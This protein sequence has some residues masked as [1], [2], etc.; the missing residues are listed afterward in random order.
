MLSDN[1]L[2]LKFRTQATNAFALTVAGNSAGI[3][4]HSLKADEISVTL[5]SI[6][7]T[8]TELVADIDYRIINADI[9][10]ILNDTLTGDLKIWAIMVNHNAQNPAKLLDKKSEVVLTPIQHW[11]PAHGYH[12]YAAIHNIDL[13]DDVDPAVFGVTERTQDFTNDAIDISRIVPWGKPQVGTTWLDTHEVDY[14]PYYDTKAFPD[15][16]DRISYW[17][18]LADWSTINV[19]EWVRSDVAPS[20]YDAAALVEEGDITIP[21]N[22]RKAGRVRN[23]IFQLSNALAT[24]GSPA[25]AEKWEVIQT[26]IE[27]HN[28]VI[29]GTPGINGTYIFATNFIAGD[30]VNIYVNGLLVTEAVTV[31]VD[32]M[33]TV[34]CA[35]ADYVQ[36]V[37]PTPDITTLA[38]GSVDTEKLLSHTELFTATSG[39]VTITLNRIVAV[40]ATVTVT[41]NGVEL[42]QT[43]FTYTENSN[44]I[45]LTTPASLSDSIAVTYDEKVIVNYEYTVQTEYTSV[46]IEQTYYYFW[47][48]SKSTRA[49]GKNRSMPNSEVEKTLVS[50]PAPYMFFQHPSTISD[51]TQVI[52]HGLRGWIDA[53]RRYTIRFTRDFTLRDTLEG[54]TSSLALKDKHEEWELFREGQQYHIMRSLWDKITE[55]MIGHLLTDSTIRVPSYER[56]LY[57]SKY[58]TDT[59]YG[60]GDGQAFTDGSMALDTI[61]ADLT[62]PNNSFYPIDIDEFFNENSFDTTENIITA[63]DTIY[64]T[65]AYEH[66]N[67][68]TFSVLHDAFSLKSKYP[69]IFK[70]SMVSLNGIRPLQDLGIFDD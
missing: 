22:T 59:R 43:E 62:N 42:A 61:M 51:Y 53:S 34:D 26:G 14:V 21:E 45:V 44:T 40:G 70:T 8:T 3:I 23:T 60:L 1:G 2:I 37:M 10:E 68:I 54:G 11:D 9:V 35:S 66:V 16:D 19:Y 25:E 47:V 20:D 56:E 4:H 65:F 12:Y 63:M 29:D 39:Q 50:V 38:A 33:I 17:G 41:V 13:Q 31:P 36:I 48:K 58:D 57:D 52:L 32:K 67:R 28:P 5:T 46:G 69:D 6:T 24:L 55:A 15:V 64:N 18:Q 30:V 27:R 7:G 49:G